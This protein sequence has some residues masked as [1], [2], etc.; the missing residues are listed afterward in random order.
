MVTYHD[1]TSLLVLGVV[2]WLT[3]LSSILRNGP[4]SPPVAETT[5]TIAASRR[6]EKF[7]NTAKKNPVNIMR[8]EPLNKILRLPTRSATRVKQ[9]PSTT[10]P[11]SVNVMKR[12][13]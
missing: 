8:Q 10:S 2:K 9:V 4:K 3:I 11:A 6:R 13:I 12:P 1:N 7:S 5:P